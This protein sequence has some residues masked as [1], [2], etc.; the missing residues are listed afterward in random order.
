[1]SLAGIV[2]VDVSPKELSPCGAR[3]RSHHE[4]I[5]KMVRRGVTTVAAAGN[6]SMDAAMVTPAAHPEVIA[7]SAMADFDG[8]PGGLAATPEVCRPE[9]VGRSPRLLLQLRRSGRH[10]RA[11]GVRDEHLPGK[12]VRVRGWHQLLHPVRGRRGRAVHLDT[13]AR[14]ARQGARRVGREGRTGTDP[15]RP[16]PLPRRRAQRP[17]PLTAVRRAGSGSQC[18]LDRAGLLGAEG[19]ESVAATCRAERVGQHR[20]EV[21]RPC[22]TRSR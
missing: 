9:A 1:M 4:A 2:G 20:R 18:D 22:P 12:P 7:V 10:R 15:R 6:Y 21:D 17:R 19:G 3:P 11:R 16:G 13:S 14:H 5:C 8:Q